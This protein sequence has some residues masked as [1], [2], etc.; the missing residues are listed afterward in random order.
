[1]G[2]RY[3]AA[4]LDGWT[5]LPDRRFR[6]LLGMARTVMD[7]PRGGKPAGTYWRGH[8]RLAA[9]LRTPLP[10][11]TPE[12]RKA[13]K[14]ILRNIR[15]ELVKLADDGAVKVVDIGQPVRH[16]HAQTY[17][18]TFDPAGLIEPCSAGS[19]KPSQE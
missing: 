12:F 11:D 9:M 15:R 18:L 6:L 10:P 17:R 13:R 7:E 8:E 2:W 3:I 19:E 14:N 5:H 16:G 1:M 4:V